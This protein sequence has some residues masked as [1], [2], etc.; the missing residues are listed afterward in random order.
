MALALLLA[1]CTSA[2]RPSAPQETVAASPSGA[3]LA[4]SAPSAGVDAASALPLR[5]L[6]VGYAAVS[7]R[8]TPLWL[9]GDEGFFQR[10]GLDVE[11]IA[12]RS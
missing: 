1:A 12:I 10:R 8:V 9:A 6:R 5:K 4:S 2:E 3:G 7:P 11:V